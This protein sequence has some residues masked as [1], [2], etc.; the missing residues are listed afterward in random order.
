M[1]SIITNTNRIG[2]YTSSEIH[3]LFASKRVCETYLEEKAI[4]R[5]IGV[6]IREDGGGQAANWGHAMEA[7]VFEKY[8]LSSMDNEWALMSSNTVRHPELQWA[9]TP[10]LYNKSLNIVGDIKCFGRKKFAQI[11]NCFKA[12]NL[13]LF[14]ATYASEYWQLVSN[15]ALMGCDTASIFV[16][17]PKKAE[18]N[19]IRDWAANAEFEKPWKYRFIYENEDYELSH[20][21]NESEFDS[22]IE[23][24]FIVLE[25]EIEL[26]KNQ[27]KLV[28]K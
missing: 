18:L 11:A 6:S 14:K 7:Y 25:S 17:L 20:Q 5:Q 22:L 21:A 26:L 4:E 15:A 1:S 3:K 12:G 28:L 13:E 19:D 16:Y 2:C 27:I 24:Q 8:F 9:G 10:D 23:F